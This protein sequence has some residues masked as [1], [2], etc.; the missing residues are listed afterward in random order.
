MI[1]FGQNLNKEIFSDHLV[2][3][4]FLY[5]FWIII[6]AFFGLYDLKSI[7]RYSYLITRISISIIF[8]IILSVLFFYLFP[9]ITPKTN[10]LIFSVLIWLFTLITRRLF[11]VVFS[12]FFKTK[13]S[14]MIE[15][16]ELKEAITEHPQLGFQLTDENPDII[17][18]EDL[19]Y[20]ALL[21]KARILNTIQAYELVLQRI[22]LNKLTKEWIFQNLNE[23]DVYDKVKRI[24]DIIMG[25]VFIIITSPF[26]LISFVLIKLDGGPIFY[27]EERYGKKLKNIK[28]IKL[29]TMKE[30]H[31]GTPWTE[32]KDDPR[33]T[34]IGKILRFLHIDE[35]PQVFNIIKGDLSFI[36]PRPESLNTVEFL[37]K[38]IPYYHLRHFIKPG[39]TGWAQ[40]DSAY[41]NNSGN[42]SSKEDKIAYDFR[43]VEYDLYYIKNRSFI[44]DLDILLKSLKLFFKQ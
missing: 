19:D 5:I 38:E 4:S 12:S 1:G 41:E 24:I 21:R 3:F 44:L 13:I 30:N 32:G 7:K 31:S 28:I 40:L 37:E 35:F 15:E 26:V 22:P 16:N 23:R 33:I 18:S 14:I 25:I 29:R 8:C 34:K 2:S 20:K 39:A 27:I 17:V 10:L 11:V 9:L 42:I 6:F 36:G 43:K